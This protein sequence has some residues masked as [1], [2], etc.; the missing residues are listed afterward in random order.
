MATHSHMLQARKHAGIAIAQCPSDHQLA[1]RLHRSKGIS[2]CPIFHERREGLVCCAGM[3]EAPRTIRGLLPGS[4]P[5]PVDFQRTKFG[6]SPSQAHLPP[7]GFAVLGADPRHCSEGADG[8]IGSFEGRNPEISRQ[9]MAQQF[10]YTCFLAYQRETDGEKPSN[11]GRSW[12]T[13]KIPHS[14]SN[15]WPGCENDSVS[16]DKDGTNPQ[17]SFALNSTDLDW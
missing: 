5:K 1:A 7:L 8:R 16:L 9:N 6:P 12:L 11:L 3:R 17:D 10:T 13:I 2:R 15:V 14:L 4:F